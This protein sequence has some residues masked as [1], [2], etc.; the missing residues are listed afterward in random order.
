MPCIQTVM[1][2]TLPSVLPES[3][4]FYSGT[5]KH[6]QLPYSEFLAFHTWSNV[7][8]PQLHECIFLSVSCVSSIDTEHSAS[9]VGHIFSKI[10]CTRLVLSNLTKHGCAQTFPTQTPLGFS[11]L[12]YSP[13][14]F[15]QKTKR[16][17][18]SITFITDLYHSF[19]VLPISACCVVFLQ[20]VLSLSRPALQ[21]CCHDR[22]WG[23][24][25]RRRSI[26]PAL[27]VLCFP[28]QQV[29]MILRFFHTRQPSLSA[30]PPPVT[31]AAFHLCSSDLKVPVMLFKLYPDRRPVKVQ[32]RCR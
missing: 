15:T 29:A 28:E 2:S 12:S 31:P 5:Q 7:A 8:L 16:W 9:S 20:L 14:I 4:F 30:L 1:E 6:H 32:S 25:Q 13:P 17:C 23:Q 19:S 22:H 26:E 27:C 3:H 24:T 18:L 10:N 11:S 21:I